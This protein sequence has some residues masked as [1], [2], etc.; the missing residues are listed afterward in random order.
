MRR[1]GFRLQN[2]QPVL[3]GLIMLLPCAHGHASESSIEK[4]TR[5]L[6]LQETEQLLQSGSEERSRLQDEI[7]T[8]RNDRARLNQD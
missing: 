1:Y 6:E 2:F 3:I 5:Q 4:A 8:L 7:E